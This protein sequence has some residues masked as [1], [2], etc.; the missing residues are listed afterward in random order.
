M[1]TG[2]GEIR[3]VSDTA[4]MTAA[5]RAMETERADGL[6]RDLYAA[7]L[8]AERGMAI[9]R[10]MPDLDRVCFGMGLRTRYLDELVLATIAGARIQCVLNVGAGLDSRP[11]R[12]DLPADLRW[13]EVDLPA[14]LEYK[15]RVMADVQP[16]CRREAMVVDVCDA[17]ARR[18]MFDAAGSDAVLLITEGLLPYLPGAVVNA[19]AASEN[20]AHHWLQDVISPAMAALG[21]MDKCRPIEDVRAP[22]HLDGLQTIAALEQHGWRRKIHRNYGKDAWPFAAARLQAL[23]RLRADSTTVPPALPPDDPTGVHLFV[24]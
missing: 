10:A 9:A 7:R 22:D 19:L 24:R 4:L 20:V 18:A 15:T 6:I 16:R 2:P 17:E 12:L 8:A 5:C 13:I 21:R 14:M 1:E 23:L 11:W 3:H